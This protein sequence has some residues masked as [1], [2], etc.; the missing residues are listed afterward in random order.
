MLHTKIGLASCR[1]ECRRRELVRFDDKLIVK[2]GVDEKAQLWVVSGGLNEG[3]TPTNFRI[4][5]CSGSRD[6]SRSNPEKICTG[7]I[8]TPWHFPYLDYIFPHSGGLECSP[9]S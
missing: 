9:E 4:F 7:E 1:S 8:P 3:N 2:E 6:T 5:N